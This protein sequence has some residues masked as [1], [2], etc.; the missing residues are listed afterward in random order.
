MTS[1]DTGKGKIQK[2]CDILKKETIEP[3][4]QEA[5]EIVENAKMQSEEIV[6][7][8]KNRANKTIEDAKKKMEEE[9]RTFE[10]SLRLASKQAI[11]ELKQ[12]IE[13]NLFSDALAKALGEPT[14]DP[15]LIA[16]LINCIVEA[17]DKEGLDVDISAYISKEVPAKEVTELLLGKV[18]ER[19]HEGAVSFGDF[20]GGVMVKLNEREITIDIT[21]DAVKNLLIEYV[22]KE[23]REMLFNA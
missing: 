7:E 14:K 9:K 3:A 21:R 16:K 15:K 8:A 11:D 5:G 13:E 23:F 2:I 4:K 20:I 19:L 22:R 10:A 12:Q 1:Q 18:K 6:Q 17:I